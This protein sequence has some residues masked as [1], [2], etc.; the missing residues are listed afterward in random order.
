MFAALESPR[1]HT[2]RQAWDTDLL[3]QRAR[4]VHNAL[5]ALAD[6]DPDSPDKAERAKADRIPPAAML[7][8]WRLQR[9]A[10]RYPEVRVVLDKLNEIEPAGT[11]YPSADGREYR[12]L[13][14]SEARA[15]RQA[16]K[17]K[18][19]GPNADPVYGRLS[20][21]AEREA[22][23]EYRLRRIRPGHFACRYS[24]GRGVNA[25]VYVKVQRYPRLKFIR[26]WVKYLADVNAGDRHLL[27][28]G[29]RKRQQHKWEIVTAEDRVRRQ[30]KRVRKAVTRVAAQVGQTADG[31]HALEAI[32]AAARK[33]LGQ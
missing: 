22:E 19:I 17:A 18:A 16:R 26:W 6:A 27:C 32:L 15:E 7:R 31:L 3:R 10:R 12:G 5:A 29:F 28:Y 21:Q 9:L 1:L 4:V 33:R 30:A 11:H 20:R 13:D 25:P 2:P 8:S 23:A 24:G 14:R